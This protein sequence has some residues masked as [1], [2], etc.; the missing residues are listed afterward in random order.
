MIRLQQLAN[1]HKPKMIV[2]GASAYALVID[3]KRFRENCRQRWRLSFCGTWHIT[4]VMIA[5][6]YYPSP[7]G[8][9]RLRHYDYP[10]D[11]CARPPSRAV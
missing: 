9:R 6:G 1:E 11:P 2:A 3:W 8:H 10:Q 7:G 5:A 4:P